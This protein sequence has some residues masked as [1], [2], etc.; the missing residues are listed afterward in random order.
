MIKRCHFSHHWL[1]LCI[2]AAGFSSPVS[3]ELLSLADMGD[4]GYRG[5]A[6]AIEIRIGQDM[7][8]ELI[9]YLHLEIDA[10]DVSD[11]VQRDA[12]RL[13]FQPQTPL[14]P[15]MHELRVVA[16]LPD[17]TI[18]EAAI[19]S[20]EV[21]ASKAFRIA[22]FNSNTSLQAMQRISD[23][24]PNP[25]GERLQGQGAV[26]LD[27]RHA[28]DDWELTGQANMIYNSQE[29]QNL[30]GDEFE[31]S[32]YQ[33]KQSWNQSSITLGHQV[34]SPGSL[35]LSD[36]SRRGLSASYHSEQQRFQATGFSTRTE[37]ITGFDHFTGVDDADNRTSGVVLT[38]YPFESRPEQLAVS[39][40]YLDSK[41]VSQGVAQ[42]N[43]TAPNTG[44]DAAALILDSYPG[45]KRWR[46]R[47]EYASTRFDF[48][49]ENT[50]FDAEEDDAVTLSAGYD[51]GR[52]TERAMEA[53]SSWNVNLMHQR[54]GPWFYSLGNTGVTV[55]RET[56]Q[57]AGNYQGMALGLNGSISLGEDNVDKVNTLPTTE[58]KTAMFSLNY[59]PQS[60]P[61][62][63]EEME[64]EQSSESLF[65][66]P[67][68]SLNWSMHDLDQIITPTGFT[69]DDVNSRYQELSLAATF[70]GSDWYWSLT[71]SWIGQ[72][73][74]V[75]ID[76]VSDTVSTS[77]ESQWTLN[78]YVSLSPVLQQSVTEYTNMAV[79]TK[80][81]LAGVTLNINYPDNWNNSLT[82]T[83]NRETDSEGTI[84]SRTRIAELML[85]WN[86]R[87]AGQ[88]KAGISLFTSASHQEVE[89]VGADMDQYQVFLGVNVAWPASL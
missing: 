88:N 75:Y 35:V 62:G 46:L 64:Q 73:D 38:A 31:L 72:D 69:G 5:T 84:D 41:G 49:G 4:K 59:T 9:P 79:E 54:V 48:D 17:G 25:P 26:A 58:I 6:D 70:S 66:N 51:V 61:F 15:G 27:S 32:D 36:F 3:A 81:W 21:R 76:N 57:L 56:T 40:I 83:V 30:S 44:G 85:Q 42:V 33:L 39:A 43:D 2:L 1:L 23:D 55:D 82:Y 14:E 34:I 78:D 18:E 28:D 63:E 20:V 19:W 13:V 11:F 65:S 89:Q 8:A 16:V 77:L 71:Q 87:Q 68:Y 22:N 24:L 53:D 45:N 74:K 10:I 67:S 47:G 7:P 52:D 29:S 50:G 12:Q 37:E 60:D 80:S 86:V